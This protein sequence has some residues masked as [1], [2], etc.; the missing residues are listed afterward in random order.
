MDVWV[1]STAQ[2]NASAVLATESSLTGNKQIIANPA[3]NL[4]VNSTPLFSTGTTASVVSSNTGLGSSTTVT[5]PS[6]GTGFRHAFRGSTA[7][8]PPSNGTSSTSGLAQGMNVSAL[9]VTPSAPSNAKFTT[10]PPQTSSGFSMPKITAANSA[11]SFS[12]GSFR[13]SANQFANN[14]SFSPHSTPFK[15]PNIP[16]AAVAATTG[17]AAAL[18]HGAVAPP[19]GASVAHTHV[20]AG[21][22]GKKH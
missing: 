13:A 10:P 4:P 21:V 16:P 7:S 6:S 3:S 9:Q 19:P 14:G 12:P 8:A 15:A 17:A 2:S 22:G 20:F 1:N 18:S 5:S 11:P